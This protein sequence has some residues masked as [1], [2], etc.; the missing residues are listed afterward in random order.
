MSKN[1]QSLA[2][3]RAKGKIKTSVIK[4]N[5]GIGPYDFIQTKGVEDSEIEDNVHLST[6]PPSLPKKKWYEKPFGIVL[7]MVIAGLILALLLLYLGLN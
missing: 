4:D 2:F 7:L 6:T 1:K 5:V 3:I